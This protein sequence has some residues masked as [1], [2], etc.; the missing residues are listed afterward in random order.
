M[1]SKEPKLPKY[2][3]W[4]TPL[5]VV[6]LGLHGLGLLIPVPERPEKEPIEIEEI[7]SISVSTLPPILAPA[8]ADDSVPPP[9]PVPLPPEQLPPEPPPIAAP[10]PP[11]QLSPVPSPPEEPLL[12]PE[13]DPLVPAMPTLAPT[14]PTT[15]VT[16]TTP[17][18]PPTR[19][20]YSRANVNFS[21]AQAALTD[22]FAPGGVGDTFTLSFADLKQVGGSGVLTEIT[23]V[24]P[25]PNSCLDGFPAAETFGFVAVI[26]DTSDS[27]GQPMRNILDVKLLQPTTDNDV[28]SWL[29][30]TVIFGDATAGINIYNEIV[31]QANKMGQLGDREEAVSFRIRVL[32]PNNPC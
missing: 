9:S 32:F 8:A 19:R 17:I 6:S 27:S 30:T 12:P 29:E 5:L 22:F 31:A 13:P 26:G 18:I 7:E 3:R 10:L 14:T 11:E 15:P 1:T 16:P 24:D 20:I 25:D 23:Y 28:D 4:L 21:A 2:L